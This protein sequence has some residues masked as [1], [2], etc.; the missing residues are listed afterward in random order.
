MQIKDLK[1]Y[2][3]LDVRG[4]S[5]TRIDEVTG[6]RVSLHT[7]IPRRVNFYVVVRSRIFWNH[8]DI[9]KGKKGGVEVLRLAHA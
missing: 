9:V 1:F 7:R 6:E 4:E 2:S 3:V 5:I 8:R